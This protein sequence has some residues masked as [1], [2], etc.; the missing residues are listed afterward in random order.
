V[1]MRTF[2][3]AQAEMTSPHNTA[4]RAD[5]LA[6]ATHVSREIGVSMDQQRDAM[7]GARRLRSREQSGATSGR[8]RWGRLRRLM[9]YP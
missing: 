7:K 4:V 3:E 6:P 9:C 5:A 1:R 2:V 8:D